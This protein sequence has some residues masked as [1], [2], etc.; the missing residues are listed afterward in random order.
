MKTSSPPVKRKRQRT[1]WNV[2]ASQ[3]AQKTFNPIRSIVDGMKLSPNPEKPMIA[4]SIGK[5]VQLALFMYLL[6]YKSYL[7]S[8][9][10]C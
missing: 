8:D 4:L 1:T 9:L 5:H 3:I 2:S 6:I 7:V 10:L